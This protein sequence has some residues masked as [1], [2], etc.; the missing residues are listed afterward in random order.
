[1]REGLVE[2]SPKSQRNEAMAEV[3]G[4]ERSVKLTS[5]GRGPERG[6]AEKLAVGPLRGVVIAF[7]FLAH[8]AGI[9]RTNAVRARSTPAVNLGCI[10]GY[11]LPHRDAGNPP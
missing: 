7:F 11:I 1:M 10:P 6:V 2:P 4:T 8:P 3:P 5:S 9:R